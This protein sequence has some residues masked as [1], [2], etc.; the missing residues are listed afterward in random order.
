MHSFKTSSAR[1]C[2]LTLQSRGHA[3]ASRGMPLISN[4]SRHEELR[5]N[6]SLVE[7]R[8]QRQSATSIAIIN[9]VQ[10]IDRPRAPITVS[11][12]TASFVSRSNVATH[13]GRMAR[14]SFNASAQSA[15]VAHLEFLT[16][17]QHHRSEAMNKQELLASL[18]THALDWKSLRIRRISSL[19]TAHKSTWKHEQRV[20]EVTANPSFKRTRLR[21]SA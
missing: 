9:S 5:W 14:T 11:C 21:R 17:D 2:C 10:G 16:D 19:R 13:T 6:S 20:V 15:K 18:R 7:T 4:V 3:P 12:R 8:R 1:R